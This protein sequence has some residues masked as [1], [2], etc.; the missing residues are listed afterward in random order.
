MAYW[1]ESKGD[2]EKVFEKRPVVR[3]V[4]RYKTMYGSNRFRVKAYPRFSANVG[5]L[6]RDLDMLYR[7]DSFAP[8]VIVVDYADILK[9]EDS[10]QIG[11][12]RLDETWKSLARMAG[13]RHCLVITASQSNR[14]SIYKKRVE[15][16]DTAEDIR[17]LAHVD[18][19]LSLNQTKEEKLN[20]I[21]RI[22]ILAHRHR[23][24]NEDFVCYVLQNLETG[25]VNLDSEAGFER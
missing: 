14:G 9:P 23:D 25:Q 6:E 3:E 4:G 7:D 17:K 5:D 22:G 24:F 8:D 20:G 2:N 11:R 1:F 18:V 19:M 21:M 13:Q 10:R 16:D 12:D 15:Q